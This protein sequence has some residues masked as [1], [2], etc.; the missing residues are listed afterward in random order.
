[1][2]NGA[3]TDD[4]EVWALAMGVLGYNGTEEKTSAGQS[5]RAEI[6]SCG[7]C[8]VTCIKCLSQVLEQV[9]SVLKPLEEKIL[10][11]QE[12][13]ILNGNNNIFLANPKAPPISPNINKIAGKRQEGAPFSEPLSP[14]QRAP[15]TSRWLERG[16][17]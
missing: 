2:Q 6:Q 9:F 11:Y 16:H 8:E 10:G 4:A 12:F 15:L 13:I 3:I 5:E 17:M 14:S 7:Q 1:M